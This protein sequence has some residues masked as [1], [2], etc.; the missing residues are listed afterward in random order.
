MSMHES[1]KTFWGL[2]GGGGWGMDYRGRRECEESR[3]GVGG[4]GGFYY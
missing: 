1:I 2:G 4:G 3:E